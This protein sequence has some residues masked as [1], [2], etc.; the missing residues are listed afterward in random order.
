MPRAAKIV[1]RWPAAQGAIQEIIA[2]EAVF[3]AGQQRANGNDQHLQHVVT[4]GIASA[5]IVKTRKAGSKSLHGSSHRSLDLAVKSI[6]A[7]PASQ[8]KPLSREFQMQF[9]WVKPLTPRLRK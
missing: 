7:T 8:V 4:P 5:R 6:R 3:A 1:T 9:P 2:Q